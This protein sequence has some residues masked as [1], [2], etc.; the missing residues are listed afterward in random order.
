MV[1]PIPAVE[2]GSTDLPSLL[3][4]PTSCAATETAHTAAISLAEETSEDSHPARPV[5]CPIGPHVEAVLLLADGTSVTGVS[6][7]AET[8]SIAGECVFQTG[9]CND[10]CVIAP[11][12]CTTNRRV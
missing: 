7:G 12:I 5:H 2:A 6:F 10:L 4:G 1:V 3:N 9:M 8:H 11:T